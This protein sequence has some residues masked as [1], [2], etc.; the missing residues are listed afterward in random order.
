MRDE[1]LRYDLHVLCDLRQV[2]A[3]VQEVETHLHASY[4]HTAVLL[5][6]GASTSLRHGFFVVEWLDEEGMGEVD[7]ELLAYL[8]GDQ[9]TLEVCVYT[10][11]PSPQDEPTKPREAVPALAR[12]RQREEQRHGG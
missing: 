6:W 12:S 5:D 1:L 10:P 8:Q 7:E 11:L 3:Q 4:P 2:L 9:R